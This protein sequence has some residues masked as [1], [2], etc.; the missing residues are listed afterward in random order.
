MIYCKKHTVWHEGECEKCKNNYP[1]YLR[2]K[3]EVSKEEYEK[4]KKEGLTK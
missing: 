2:S 1:P 4:L 3:T